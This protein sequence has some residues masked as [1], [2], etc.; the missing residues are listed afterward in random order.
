[1]SNQ[2]RIPSGRA[3][4]NQ[5][6]RDAVATDAIALLSGVNFGSVVKVLAAIE[7]IRAHTGIE[8]NDI[9]KFTDV[10]TEPVQFDG[11]FES[12]V[13]ATDELVG[14]IVRGNKANFLDYVLRHKKRFGATN[15]N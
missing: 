14:S 12:R 4:P 10:P 6:N 15:C 11:T 9:V 13:T 8:P 3:M 1:M 2:K 7:A 5:P